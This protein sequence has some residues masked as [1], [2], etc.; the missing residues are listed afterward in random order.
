MSQLGRGLGAAAVYILCIL[1]ATAYSYRYADPPADVPATLVRLF[2]LQILLVLVCAIFVARFGSWRVFGFGRVNWPA[3]IWLF[4]SFVVMG[5]MAA[6]LA[7]AWQAGAFEGLAPWVWV[8][9]IGVPLLI[10][11]GEEV[12]F[13]GILLRSAQRTL[14]VPLAMTL[15]A[16]LFAA[17]HAPSGLIAQPASAT[18]QNTLFALT[19]GLFLAPVALRL[20]NLW[21]LI[22]WHAVWNML[23][24]ASQIAGVQHGFVLIGVLIQAAVAGWLWRDFVRYPVRLAS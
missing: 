7:P 15:S 6:G 16:V 3:L 9:L 5:A 17:M 18:L 19:V 23:V 4:P 11:F 12:M 2:V 10:G 14:P 13:R 1:M 8:L 22:I 20:G 21:P 24:F